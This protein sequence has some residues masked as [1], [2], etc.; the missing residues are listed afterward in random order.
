MMFTKEDN[1]I[2]DR[3]LQ[4]RWT[5]RSFGDEIHWPEDC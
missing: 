3:I 2:L 1:Q 4:A 5:C